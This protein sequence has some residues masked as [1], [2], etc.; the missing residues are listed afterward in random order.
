MS[1]PGIA[2]ERTQGLSRRDLA[3]ALAVVLPLAALIAPYRD[4][5]LPRIFIMG[6]ALLGGLW[7]LKTALEDVEKLLFVFLLYI[8]FQK[9]LPGD[10]GGM[11]RAVNFTNAFL[12]L[13]LLGWM[14]R[15]ATPVGA[16]VAKRVSG[17][18]AILVLFLAVTSVSMAATALRHEGAMGYALWADLKRWLMPFAIYFLVT[19]TGSSK[20][21]VKLMFLAVLVTTAVIGLLGVKQFW[22]DMGGGTR[23]NL[24]GIRIA[25]TS[26]PS[27]LGAFFAYYLPFFIALWL[28]FFWQLRFWALLAPIGWCLDSLRTTFS[29]GALVALLAATLTIVWKKSKLAFLAVAVLSA[30]IFQA[31]R[32]QLP[33]SIFGRMRTT[34]DAGRPGEG[35]ADKLD[36]SSRKRI[37]IWEGGAEMMRDYPLFGVGYGRFPDVIGEYEPTVANMDPHNNF[38][39]IGCEMGIPA[40]SLFVLLLCLCFWRGWRLYGKTDDPLLRAILLGYCGSVV[41]LVVANLFGSRLESAEISTAFWAMTGGIVVLYR[42]DA[43]RAQRERLD[44]DLRGPDGAEIAMEGGEDA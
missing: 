26:G 33:Y 21:T 9:V 10:F 15:V 34:Y 43:Q 11:A 24:E 42:L 30:L 32:L 19:A 4:I 5:H 20:K 37:T 12:L 22:M 14:A 25:V 7:C 17:I 28:T 41:G 39:K 27:N 13:L 3:L 8:P 35:F 6:I 23:A 1:S 16:Y 44:E 18:G 36:T 2:A 29:R 31:G 40:L 38:L